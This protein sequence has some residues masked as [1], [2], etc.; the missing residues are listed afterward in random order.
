MNTSVSNPNAVYRRGR[1]PSKNKTSENATNEVISF[2]KLFP[3]YE[4]HYGRSSSQKQYLHHNLNINKLYEEYKKSCELKNPQINP[5]SLYIFLEIF[6]TKFNL[7]FKRR[8][9]D[10]FKTCDEYDCALKSFIIPIARKSAIES[11][12]TKHLQLVTDVHAEFVQDVEIAQASEGT[13]SVLTFDLQKTLETPSL[14]TSVAYYKRQLWTYN[15]CANNEIEKK[16][17]MYVW[18]ENIAS[19]DEQ[20][21]GSC[22]LKHIN[23]HLPDTIK[24]LILYSD[25]CWWPKSQ[26][27]INATSE[28]CFGL[29]SDNRIN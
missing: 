12:K 11:D 18:P 29:K 23:N 28:I 3:K 27:K 15:L 8:H 10:T 20:E 6:N 25:R 17:F 4:S 22:L 21:T 2:I 24:K 16:G 7:S 5:V 14:T 19:R 26:H 9:T 13:I 1:F